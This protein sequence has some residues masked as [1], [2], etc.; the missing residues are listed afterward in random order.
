MEASI[1][2]II[3]SSAGISVQFTNRGIRSFREAT[4]FIKELSY[5]RNADKSNLTTVFTD[6]CGTC[7]TKH[8]LLQMLANEND[9]QGLHLM[10]GIFKMNGN[11]TPKVAERL[12]KH[13]LEYIP[14]A[15]CYLRYSNEIL[16]F[17]KRNSQPSDFS[18]DLLEEIEIEPD[19]ITTFKINY[20]RNY[21]QQWLMDNPDINLSLNELWEIRENCIRDLS[22]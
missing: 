22:Q 13:N 5:G 19:Q 4:T 9:Y 6:N 18:D 15:H 10:T 11:N 14:E 16:D 7:S 2:F 3:M 1:D 21:L 8:A 20:H 12:R 17:T